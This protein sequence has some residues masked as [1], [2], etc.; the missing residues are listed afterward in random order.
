MHVP[1]FSCIGE[2]IQ[3]IVSD[4]A[5]GILTMTNWPNQ[6]WCGSVIDFLVG[7][8]FFI[9]PSEDQFT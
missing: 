8:L 5:S 2:V 1:P 6:C 7:S 4:K 3:K 9:Q